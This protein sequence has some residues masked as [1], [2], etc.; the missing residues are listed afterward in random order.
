MAL[1]IICS[2]NAS[3]HCES[4]RIIFCVLIVSTPSAPAL[5]INKTLYLSL[6]Y[7]FSDSLILLKSKKSGLPKL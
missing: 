5:L 4:I 3:F 1:A 7:F 6:I 2:L